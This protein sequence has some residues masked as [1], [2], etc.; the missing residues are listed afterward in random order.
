MLFL[1]QSSLQGSRGRDEGGRVELAHDQPSLDH[2]GLDTETR[3]GRS[4]LA[5]G[6]AGIST[7]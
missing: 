5:A 1:A 3:P 2:H 4:L 7:P 6:Q